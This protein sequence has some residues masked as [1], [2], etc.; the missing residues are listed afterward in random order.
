MNVPFVLHQANKSEIASWSLTIATQA[1]KSEGFY[2]IN[3]ICCW[4]MQ[5]TPLDSLSEQ[6]CI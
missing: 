1:A 2:A 6:F 3:A 4:D 5:T